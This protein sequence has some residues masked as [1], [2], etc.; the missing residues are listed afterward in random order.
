MSAF[1]KESDFL[2]LDLELI[3]LSVLQLIE[4]ISFYLYFKPDNTEK[5]TNI[6]RIIE[7]NVPP[8]VKKSRL[9]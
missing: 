9:D 6:F 3:H 4:N 1:N 8:A 5:K 7:V 2:N